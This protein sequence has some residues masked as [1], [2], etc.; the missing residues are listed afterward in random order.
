MKGKIKRKARIVP[1]LFPTIPYHV[2]HI[3][4]FLDAMDP[5]HPSF[6]VLRIKRKATEPPLS[7]LGP[8]PLLLHDPPPPPLLPLSHLLLSLFG[9]FNLLHVLESG[10]AETSQ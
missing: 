3:V 7:S 6:T 10:P 8:S 2:F 4:P 1:N 9:C 5:P